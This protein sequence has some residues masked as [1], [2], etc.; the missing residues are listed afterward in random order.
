MS[1]GRLSVESPRPEPRARFDLMAGGEAAFARILQ[2]IDEAE[3]SILVR[4]FE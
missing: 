4:C 1:L 2:R 3:R